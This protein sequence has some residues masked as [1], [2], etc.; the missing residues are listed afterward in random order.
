MQ[1][2]AIDSD[3]LIHDGIIERFVDLAQ[4]LGIPKSVGQIYGLLFCSPAPLTFND[5]V[6]QLNISKG[7]ASQGLRLLRDLGAVHLV[8]KTGERKDLYQAETGLR[9][10]AHGFLRNQIVPRLKDG[11][12]KLEY[13]LRESERNQTASP[14]LTARLKQLREWHRKFQKLLPWVSLVLPNKKKVP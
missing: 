3:T 10:L 5:I 9:E 8:Y 1:G 12:Q 14:H 7:S 13:I 2:T 4:M 6:E 11:D